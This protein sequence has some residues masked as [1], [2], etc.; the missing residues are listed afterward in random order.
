MTQTAASWNRGREFPTRGGRGEF[1]GGWAAHRDRARSDAFPRL[2]A[3]APRIDGLVR[4]L[5]VVAWREGAGQESPLP[6]LGPVD[7]FATLS[8][9]ARARVPGP[10]S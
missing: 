6:L 10:L 1:R 4:R 8:G 7:R 9:D 2:T 5:S 3:A